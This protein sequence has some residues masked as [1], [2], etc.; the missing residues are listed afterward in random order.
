MVY[1]GYRMNFLLESG[2]LIMLSSVQEQDEV[3]KLY[4]TAENALDWRGAATHGDVSY[5]EWLFL[6]HGQADSPSGAGASGAKSKPGSAQPAAA[7]DAGSKPAADQGAPYLFY[8]FNRDV[9]AARG[10]S[11][12][13]PSLADMADALTGWWRDHPDQL[14]AAGKAVNAFATTFQLSIDKLYTAW[15]Q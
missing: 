2:G 6:S 13:D 3:N 8:Q 4:H 1:Y 9:Q 10:N 11:I 14:E 7:E 5:L 15:G 12:K